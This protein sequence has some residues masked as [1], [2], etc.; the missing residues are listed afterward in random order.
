MPIRN[1]DQLWGLI[2]CHQYDAA[3]PVNYALR[4]AC[5]LVAQIVS[6]QY[7]SAEQR[8]FADYRQRLEVVHQQLVAA[9]AQEGGL[10]AMT[11]ATPNLLD[12]MNCGGVALFHRERWWRVGRT[13]EDADL[14]A[15][16]RWRATGRPANGSRR[17]Q[18]ACWRCRC[19]ARAA[20]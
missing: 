16:A 7:R 14:D 13:P 8:E 20:P 11:D 15:L 3:A 2:A 9:A 1:G 18:P 4:T 5:E 12:A 19:R 6:L 10:A 17:W